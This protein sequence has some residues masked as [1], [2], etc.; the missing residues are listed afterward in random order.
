MVIFA[1]HQVGIVKKI[2]N[3]PGFSPFSTGKKARMVYISS[4]LDQF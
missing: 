2:V 4:L 3:F 1:E